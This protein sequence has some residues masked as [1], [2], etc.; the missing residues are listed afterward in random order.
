MAEPTGWRH[1]KEPLCGEDD[2]YGREDTANKYLRELHDRFR[3]QHEDDG[4]HPASAGS[5][6]LV[7]QYTGDGNSSHGIGLAESITPIR[8]EIYSTGTYVPAIWTNDHLTVDPGPPEQLVPEGTKMLDSIAF[9][10]TAVTGVGAGVFF[11]GSDTDVNQGGQTYFY[12]IYG[13]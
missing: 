4:T 10:T 9:S 2:P 5:K 12:V 13:S 1:L 8:V 6:M 3:A 7:G 11:V